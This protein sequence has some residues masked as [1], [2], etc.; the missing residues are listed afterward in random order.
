MRQ[1]YSGSML[2]AVLLAAG[3]LSVPAAVA[4]AVPDESSAYPEKQADLDAV[5][6]QL[7]EDNPGLSKEEA[8]D[9]AQAASGEIDRGFAERAGANEGLQQ[10]LEQG[11]PKGLE[12]G[13]GG[14]IA[15][16]TGAE[17]ALAEKVSARG[18]EIGRELHE[19]GLSG[20]NLEKA[21]DGKLKQ[22]FEKEFNEFKEKDW[23]PMERD[24]SRLKEL[25]ERG[26]PGMEQKEG[27][28][29]EQIERYREMEKEMEKE[30]GAGEHEN[31]ESAVDREKSWEAPTQERESTERPA[32]D[33]E[34]TREIEQ[35]T[36]E[37]EQ[38]TREVEQPTREVEQPT[39]EM[40]QREG[41]GSGPAERPEQYREY[42][43]PQG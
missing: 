22:E 17:K 7:Q 18:A 33:R 40:E 31:R 36:R 13:L 8:F 25:S 30:H 6:E 23:A 39:H 28:T 42:A 3:L 16:M 26:V 32:Y 20:E 41:S 9:L 2:G 4:S 10:G 43:P 1:H 14:P 34:S 21:V 11:L 15:E 12:Q 5:I 29:K 24:D 27:P 38:P 37:V 19:Q 35:P